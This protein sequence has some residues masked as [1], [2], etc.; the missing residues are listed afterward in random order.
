MYILG[1]LKE[2]GLFWFV[3]RIV[4][5]FA[6]P[7]TVF[8]KHLKHYSFITHFIVSKPA[9][10]FYSLTRSHLK[11]N[12]SLY[13]FYDFEV[14][15]ITYDFAWALCIAN[16]RREELGLANLRVV[17]VPGAHQGLRKESKEYEEIVGFDARNWRIHAILLPITRLLSCPLSIL[18][19][20][21]RDEAQLI[22]DKQAR[23][24]YPEKYNVT[25]PVP[26]SPKLAMHY[27]QKFPALHADQQALNYI[28]NWFS[29]N[30]HG[31]QL[32]TITL[33]QYAYTPERNS[34]INAWAT[35]AN[36]LDK[37]K[38]FIVF[39]PDTEQ[40]L[41]A[42]PDEISAFHLFYPACW[43]L[44]IRSALY[45]LAYLNLGVNNGPMA[46]CWLNPMCRYITF[47]TSVPNVPQ[48]PI[49]TLL[50]RGFVPGENP[51]FA[52]PFQKWVW[53]Q[54]DFDTIRHEFRLMYDSLSGGIS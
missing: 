44:H 30:A 43:N 36:T 52:H 19:C 41:N 29:N 37:E 31:K 15:P 25:F 1:K 24:V 20:S 21:S 14:E 7:T 51:P 18:F 10:F 12:D 53:G 11:S 40:A 4:R 23:F 45:E 28:S 49:E 8:G 22:R 54:D 34:N 39:I 32:I 50:E 27:H 3:R 5:E 17:F 2:H 16:A 48:E 46:L 35:F 9:N 38:F 6:E 42:P 47:K 33:R 13:F 26:Y